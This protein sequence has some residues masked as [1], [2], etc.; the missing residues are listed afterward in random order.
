MKKMTILTMTIA[1]VFLMNGCDLEDTSDYDTYSSDYDAGSTQSSKLSASQT[2][3]GFIINWSK[4]NSGYSEVIYTDVLSKTRGNGYPL[5]TNSKGSYTLSC[6][7]YDQDNTYIS[8]SCKP[9]NVTYSKKVNFEKGKEYKWLVSDGTDHQHG[10]VEFT[11]IY[12][13]GKL[14]IE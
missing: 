11:M 7:V 1:S 12:Q 5:T 8:Y 4:N 9:S 10:E 6:E 14:S 3:N 13:D 2:S